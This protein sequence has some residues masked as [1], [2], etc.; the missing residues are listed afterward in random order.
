MSQK[1]TQKVP[2]KIFA[3]KKKTEISLIDLNEENEGEKIEEKKEEKN[4]MVSNV[5]TMLKD[6]LRTSLMK[7]R[8]SLTHQNDALNTETRKYYRTYQIKFGD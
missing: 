5:G 7:S 1:S 2:E 3:I 6:K 8:I 4:E